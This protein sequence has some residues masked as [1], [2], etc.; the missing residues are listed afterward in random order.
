M[1]II[2]NGAATWLSY[3]RA[4]S[5]RAIMPP[6]SLTF[7]VVA[8]LLAS[9]P[10]R[11]PTNQP[12]QPD[13][14]PPSA[15][16]TET[17]PP[18]AA[19]DPGPPTAEEV[20]RALQRTSPANEVIWPVGSAPPDPNALPKKLLPEGFALVEKTG[21]LKHDHQ[22]Y[23]FAFAENGMPAQIR[24]LPNATLEVM[25]RT[26]AHTAEPV[27]FVVSGELTVF[28]DENYLLPRLAMRASNATDDQG[29]PTAASS[30]PAAATTD[31]SAATSELAGPAAPRTIASAEDVAAALQAAKPSAL[32]VEPVEDRLTPG[33]EPILKNLTSPLGLTTPPT[34]KASFART[35][36]PEGT[37]LT[38][39]PGRLIEHGTHWLFVPE[40]NHRDFPEPPL[41]L[42]PCHNT[43]M[44][45]LRRQTDKHGVVFQVSGEIT[46]F[47]GENYLLPRVATRQVVSDNLRK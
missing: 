10:D 15:A 39:R 38:D 47:E 5:E 42:L 45:V 13:T 25:V 23:L 33:G 24:L 19:A 30:E 27:T 14:R 36:Q 44:M 29:A 11:A 4:E 31:G 3:R 34:R 8:A 32:A 12:A 7:F 20:L 16:S 43:Q 2:F 37:M 40:S 18:D 28:H 41:R 17:P 6:L 26:A 9:P 1:P 22:G 46:L 35:I 21:R